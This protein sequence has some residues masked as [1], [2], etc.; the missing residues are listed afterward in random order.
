MPDST[1]LLLD[2]ELVYETN[3]RQRSFEVM[4]DVPQDSILAHRS[5]MPCTK[6]TSTNFR[7]GVVVVLFTGDVLLTVTT[8]TLEEVEML[9]TVER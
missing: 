1:K 6:A 8:A 9:A 3:A 2:Q 4:A 7:K 5:G